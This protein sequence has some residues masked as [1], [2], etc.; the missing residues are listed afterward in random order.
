MEIKFLNKK[1]IKNMNLIVNVLNIYKVL[2]IN[3]L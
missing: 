2:Y 3:T 1:I